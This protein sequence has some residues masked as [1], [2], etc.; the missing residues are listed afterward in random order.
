MNSK[1]NHLKRY[2]RSLRAFYISHPLLIT[3]LGALILC[4]VGAIVFYIRYPFAYNLSNFYAEDGRYFIKNLIDKGPILGSLSIFNGYL[5]VGQYIVGE[6]AIVINFIVGGNFATLARSVAVASYVFLAFVCILPWLLFR[7]KIGTVLTLII[8]AALWVTPFGGYDYAVIGT[9]GNLKFAFLFIA[10]LLVIYRISKACD[11]RWKFTIINLA[12]LLCILTN[13]V[14]I[15]LLPLLLIRYWKSIKQLF[16]DRQLHPFINFDFISFFIL[17]LI[18]SAYLLVVYIHGIPATP[19]YLDGP[20]DKAALIA[21][22]YRATVYGLTFPVSYLFNDFSAIFAML[23]LAILLFWQRRNRIVVFIMAVA[24]TLNIFGFAE[25]RPG[26]TQL[27]ATYQKQADWPGHFFYAGTMIVVFA[28]GYVLARYFNRLRTYAKLLIFVLFLL[29]A[30]LFIPAA[31]YT[32]ES[33]YQKQGV[34]LPTLSQEV[35]RVCSD[36]KS[37]GTEE[38]IQLY[39]SKDWIL[40]LEKKD[41]C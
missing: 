17:G 37:L 3:L 36:T 35:K 13:I 2:I 16:K 12:I 40:N 39:P 20:A 32:V 29:A 19:G 34:M 27:F 38:S 24:L 41:I 9:I 25:A 11:T 30:G 15:G 10:T 31:G 33:P 21:L 6:L 23:G 28:V 7:K 5:I 26:V 22:T 8:T 4:I 14:A 1:L 18:S